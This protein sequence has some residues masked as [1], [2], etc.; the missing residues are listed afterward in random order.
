MSNWIEKKRLKEEQ[1]AFITRAGNLLKECGGTLSPEKETEWKGYH[2]EAQAR[3]KSL[4]A[5]DKQ[6]TAER[7]LA[8][9]VGRDI[10]LGNKSDSK[11]TL[12]RAWRKS[13]I[14]RN[15]NAS[16]MFSDE[17]RAALASAGSGWVPQIFND[18]FYEVL[19]DDTSVLNANPNLIVTNVGGSFTI[20]TLDD[21]SNVGEL[22]G[23]NTEIAESE[24]TLSSVTLNAYQY[25]SKGVYMS[26]AAVE[27]YAFSVEQSIGPALA[28]RL[29]RKLNSDM[30][31][32]DGSSKPQGCVYGSSL[33][34]TAASQTAITY[35]EVLDLIHSVPASARPGSYLMGNDTTLLALR[36]LV[37]G[38][39]NPLWNAGNVQADLPSTLAGYPY[40][41]NNA[42]AD[43]GTAAKAL[44]FG[45]FNR[46]FVVRRVNDIQLLSDFNIATLQY[47]FVCHVRMD[48][49]V[50][51][52]SVIKHLIL[53]AG[54]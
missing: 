41:T 51:D 21:G 46:G 7:S 44:L 52:S 4:E 2:D 49:K 18:T 5:I 25:S 45:N 24:P 34:K 42:M 19:K 47:I 53:A 54:S 38:S 15:K 28:R 23:E 22:V 33:G 43:I 35:N 31:L 9:L 39:G 40:V 6:E 30:T 14:A 50:I 36:K 29:G 37:D 13:I 8:D 16:V 17:E 3:A 10:E 32:G 12:S 27:D 48:S 1:A 26:Q 11:E 20:P